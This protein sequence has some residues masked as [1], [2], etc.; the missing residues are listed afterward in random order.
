[1]LLEHL[2]LRVTPEL[3]VHVVLMALPVKMDSLVDLDLLDLLDPLDPLEVQ[4][5]LVKT[6]HLEHL[7]LMAPLEKTD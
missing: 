4:D 7:V 3:P 1:M 5:L 2:D 6:E